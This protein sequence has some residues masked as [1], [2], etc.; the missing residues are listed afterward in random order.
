MSSS[1]C[2]SLIPFIERGGKF[3]VETTHNIRLQRMTSVFFAHPNQTSKDV[4]I[5]WRSFVEIT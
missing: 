1:I 4:D 2:F 5:E 3:E